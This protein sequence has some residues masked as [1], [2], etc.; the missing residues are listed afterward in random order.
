MKRITRAGIARLVAGLALALAVV[1][2]FAQ[3]WPTKPVRMIVSLG[4]GS[5]ADIGARLYADRLT[6][7]WGQPVVVENRPGADGVLA[8]NAVISAKDDHTLLW[9]PTSNF[10]AHPYTL[11][12]LPYDPNELVPVARITNTV[13]T[14]AVPPAL[15]ANSLKDL[16]AQIKAQPGKWNF[17]SA[18]TNTDVIIAAYFKSAGLDVQK[19]SY[20][21]TVSALNDLL[22]NRIQIYGA[23]YAIVRTQVQAGRVKILAITNRNRAPGLDAPTV[24]ELG[25][26]LLEFDGLVAIIA[27]RSSGLSDAARDR[28]AADV[29]TVSADPQIAERLQAT[30]QINNPGTAAELAASM[31]EQAAQLD[32][33]AKQAGIPRKLR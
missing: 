13:V 11:E 23:A 3:S 21:D 8:I 29:K 28:I 2:V 26:P 16:F 18:T 25:Y 12:S 30:A 24:T 22:E 20:K 7:I 10:I 15:G 14:I 6:K 31:K 17:A 1:P 5:G 4:A 33:A 32:A 19:V 9:G 27:A